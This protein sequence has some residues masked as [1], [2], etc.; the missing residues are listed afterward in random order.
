MHKILFYNK[1]IKYLY[2]FRVLCAHH[3]EDKIVL[4][5]TWCHQNCRWPSG[6]QVSLNLRTGGPPIG[7]MTPDAV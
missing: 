5:S 7:V 3:H 4:Y 1:F 6:A 2:M